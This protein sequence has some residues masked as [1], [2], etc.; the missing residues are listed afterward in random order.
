MI[1]V[2]T[3]IGFFLNISKKLALVAKNLE[4]RPQINVS[5]S[6]FYLIFNE[7]L[8]EFTDASI[9]HFS[10]SLLERQIGF[11]TSILFDLS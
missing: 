7:I 5:I 3:F 1:N 10:L 11:K 6:S 2:G 4:K 8:T 9:K